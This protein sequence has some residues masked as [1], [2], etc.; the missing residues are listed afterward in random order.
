[1][2]IN[3]FELR[4]LTSISEISQKDWNSLV[5]DNSPF[6]KHQFLYALEQTKCVCSQTGWQPFH[7]V[8]YLGELLV[9][10]M[11]L[12]LKSHSYGEYVFDFQWADAFQ[13]AGGKYYPKLLTSVPFTPCAGARILARA[14]N[15]AHLAPLMIEAI[16]AEAIRMKVGSYHL[17]FPQDTSLA[18]YENTSLKQRLGMQYHWFNRSY[19][20]FDEFLLSC[21][22]KARKNIKRER[23][24]VKQ[25]GVRFVVKEDGQIT[26]DDWNSFYSF[27]VSTYRKR[28]GNNGYLSL[29]FFKLI[30][31]T[32]SASLVLIFASQNGQ[33]MAAALFF[34][35]EDILYGRYWGCLEEI[36]FLHFET[37]YYQGIE[38]CINNNLSHFDAGAQGEHK[39][40]RGFGPVQTF[41][42]H[43]IENQS[44]A[45]AIEEFL[46]KE[47][48]YV[49]EAIEELTKRLPFKSVNRAK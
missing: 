22:A 26:N 6:L 35:G 25:S 42:Y 32:M 15:L 29:A 44:F 3:N 12:Y 2:D 13:Q 9:G 8:V 27:Y 17:L 31:Q 11:P 36:E 30:G 4:F 20:T 16:E 45:D 14:E 49:T 48:V 21:N 23:R 5:E 34:K 47:Q 43:W 28:S 38:Y 39:I 33:Q 40:K 19:Q 46:G 41:S 10:A 1:L 24:V 7:L 37:C 18:M